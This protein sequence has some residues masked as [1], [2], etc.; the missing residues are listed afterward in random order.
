M[1]EYNG[2]FSDIT[3][4]DLGVHA[5]R[6]A[7]EPQRHRARRDRP[8]HLRQRPADLGRRD[9]RRA[10][11]GAEGRR[12]E[13]GPGADG[14]PPLRLGLRVDRPGRP[15]DPARRGDDGAGRRHGE[16]V[17]GAARHPRRAQGPAPRPGSAR[18]L[19]DGGAARLLLRPLHGADLRPRRGEVR[20]HPRRAGRVRALLAA[21][22]GRGWAACR[23]SE[24]VVPVEVKVG[25]KTVR[26]EKDDHMRPDST[27]E[28]LAALPPVVRRRTGRSPP[29]TPPGSWTARPPS[30]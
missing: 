6:E 10:P 21:A 7:L 20:H 17:A 18:G 25:R 3:A 8:R 23:L 22:R 16:H 30:S 15:P 24:E 29:A 13:G 19:A 26:V 2:A 14:Q 1:A 11:R 4:I 27:L 9:L 28:G 5:A 12:P